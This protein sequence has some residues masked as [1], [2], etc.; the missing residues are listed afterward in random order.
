MAGNFVNS[1]TIGVNLQGNSDGATALFGL[2]THV[3]GN[4]ST[5]FVYVNAGIA[6]TTGQMLS[7][8]TSFTAVP[9]SLANVINPLVGIGGT[10]LAFAQGAFSASDYGWVA[11]RGDSLTVLLSTSSTLGAPLYVGGS[12]GGA[13][14][15]NTANSGTLAGISLVT[16]SATGTITAANVAYIVWPR[17]NGA[18]IA[19]GL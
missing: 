2:G 3:L 8:N 17:A 14:T 19:G 6:L 4:A 15:T 5:E 12:N 13:L 10:Q 18:A 7:I 11:L 1:S 16:A 9:A